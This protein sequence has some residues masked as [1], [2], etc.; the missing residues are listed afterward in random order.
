MY[1]QLSLEPGVYAL[2]AKVFWKNWNDHECFLTVY[3][4]EKVA[5]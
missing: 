5:F 2:S 4:V 1:V 3:G